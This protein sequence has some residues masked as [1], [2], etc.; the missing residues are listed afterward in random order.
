MKDEKLDLTHIK[1]HGVRQNNLK[2]IDVVHT[3]GH[4]LTHAYHIYSD[5]FYIPAVR[6]HVEAY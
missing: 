6:D 3:L 4:E 5:L 1:L 2:N